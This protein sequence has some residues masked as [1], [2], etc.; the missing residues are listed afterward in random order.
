MCVCVCV[1]ACVC[2]CVCLCVCAILLFI[3]VILKNASKPYTVMILAQLRNICQQMVIS[4]LPFSN[5]ENQSI[6][7]KC[8]LYG[9]SSCFNG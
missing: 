5:S 4:F 2:L 6:S 7:V 1:C 9:A 3:Q 8:L